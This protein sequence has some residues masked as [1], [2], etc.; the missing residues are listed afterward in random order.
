M[1]STEGPPLAGVVLC[2]GGSTRMGRDKALIEIDGVPL[3]Q[4]VAH[5]LAHAA[6]PVFLAPGRTGRLGEVGYPNLTDAEPDAGP[7]GGIVSALRASPHDRVAVVAVDMPFA[8]GDVFR[9][10]ADRIGEANAAV[11]VTSDGPQPLHAVF[12]RSALPALE[13]ALVD[14]SRS[15][16]GALQT[17]QVRMVGPDEWHSADPSGRFAVNVNRPEDLASIAAG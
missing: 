14:G 17:L 16:K 8:S 12:A 10:L 15:V 13:Q 3:F 9:L 1:P 7:L 2:G 11:P 4:V 6:W 5:R